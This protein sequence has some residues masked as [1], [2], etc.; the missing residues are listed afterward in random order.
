[1]YLCIYVDTMTVCMWMRCMWACIYVCVYVCRCMCVN[2]CVHV[3]TQ[4]RM[5]APMYI[6][7][8]RLRPPN[9][10]TRQKCGRSHATT[11]T[12]A[13]WSRHRGRHA[14]AGKQVAQVIQVMFVCGYVH[15]ARVMYVCMHVGTYVCTVRI[16]IRCMY[17]RMHV[18]M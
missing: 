16:V 15:V 11:P 10:A 5:H 7:P 18:S 8:D 4:A 17:V 1:M 9:R 6:Q 2:V 3:G 12:T 14:Q 13:S